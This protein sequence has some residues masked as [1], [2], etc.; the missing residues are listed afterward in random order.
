MSF[1]IIHHDCEWHHEDFTVYGPHSEEDA[2][3]IADDLGVP[4]DGGYSFAVVVSDDR[5]AHWAEPYEP[6]EDDEAP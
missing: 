6:F 3:L 4:V 1:Y 2:T 5:L